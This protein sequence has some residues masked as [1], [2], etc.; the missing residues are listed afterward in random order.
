MGRI[1]FEMGASAKYVPRNPD[2]IEGSD[3]A[4]FQR[5]GPELIHNRKQQ[6]NVLSTNAM[7]RHEFVLADRNDIVLQAE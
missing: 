3:E 6:G 5:K 2:E 7:I 1:V 4:G